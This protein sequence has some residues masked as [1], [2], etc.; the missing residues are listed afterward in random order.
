M[1]KEKVQKKKIMDLMHL[2]AEILHRNHRI[3]VITISIPLLRD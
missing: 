2:D 3:Q 1:E